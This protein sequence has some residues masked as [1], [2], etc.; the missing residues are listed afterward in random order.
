EYWDV[1]LAFYPATYY[2]KVTSC[3]AIASAS[4]RTGCA[5]PSVCS[6][7]AAVCYQAYDGNWLLE[8]KITDSA[9][10]QNFANWF[11]Y[12]RKHTLLLASA[13]GNVLTPIT[14]IRSGVAQMNHLPSSLTVYDLSSTSAS[15]NVQALLAPIYT[16]PANGS[17]PTR[18]AL[19][20]IGQQYQN[21]PGII[22]YACQANAAMVLTDGFAVADTSV[23]PPSYDASQWMSGSPFSTITAHSLAD[24]AAS[25]YTNNLNSSFATGKVPVDPSALGAS[26]DRN[27][28]LHML[29]YGFTLGTPGLI[30]GQPAYS[31]FNANPYGSWP[32]PFSDWPTPNLDRNPS[33]VDDL[34]HATINGRG[35]MFMASDA[36][37][38]TSAIQNMI[39]DRKSV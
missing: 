28:N 30:F 15:S 7:A 21:N 10:L 26:A 34:W 27:P 36:A 18:P 29:T 4:A 11:Q 37:G 12:Y 17:T 2:Q 25:Y 16:N 3:A 13:M 1:A 22:Q 33:A 31:A 8:T 35:Q 24:I 38:A 6:A 39:T 9:G 20:F 19:N 5:K 32:S 23:T 14:T